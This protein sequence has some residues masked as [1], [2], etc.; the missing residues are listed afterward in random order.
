MKELQIRATMNF[1]ALH[2]IML[3]KISSNLITA[4]KRYSLLNPTVYA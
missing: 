1:D 2:P 3:R 4:I